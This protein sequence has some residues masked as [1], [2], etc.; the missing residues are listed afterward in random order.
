MSISGLGPHG[1]RAAPP[2]RV[3]LLPE[4]I[5]A[6][7]GLRVALVMHTLESD[8]ARQCLSGI[9]GTFWRL[10]HGGD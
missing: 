10:R 6:V 9:V 8:W 1:E 5:A 2:E 4:D 3:A 7:K